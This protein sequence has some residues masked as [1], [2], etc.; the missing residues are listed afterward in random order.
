MTRKQHDVFRLTDPIP[1]ETA[2]LHKAIR[3]ILELMQE[4]ELGRSRRQRRPG[5]RL[6]F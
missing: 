3:T 2:D 4:P 5:T 1:S 6:A